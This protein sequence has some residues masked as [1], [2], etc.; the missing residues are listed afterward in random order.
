MNY[1]DVIKSVL[2]GNKE[3]EYSEFC[4]AL[5][6]LIKEC[7][8]DIGYNPD[9]SIIEFSNLGKRYYGKKTIYF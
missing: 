5:K 4:N 9:E 3:Y 6:E 1:L 2:I 7:I 8:R